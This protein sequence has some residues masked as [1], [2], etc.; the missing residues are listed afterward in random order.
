MVTVCLHCLNIFLKEVVQV[1]TIREQVNDG[2]TLL[3]LLFLSYKHESCFSTITVLCDVSADWMS[4]VFLLCVHGH[5]WKA[6][7][8]CHVSHESCS[9][10]L[11]SVLKDRYEV[12]GRHIGVTLHTGTQW[13]YWIQSA[14]FVCLLDIN[15]CVTLSRCRKTLP[16]Y[17]TKRQKK[18]WVCPL[19]VPV[20]THSKAHSSPC[21]GL[22]MC[23]FAPAL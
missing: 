7:D 6:V 21:S 9:P 23:S 3:S 12:L 14:A 5:S 17:C 20:S 11:R 19:S 4:C 10:T 2:W 8:E 13:F 18:R 1:W 22:L 15:L 16:C